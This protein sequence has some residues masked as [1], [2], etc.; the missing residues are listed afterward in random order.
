MIKVLKFNWLIMLLMQLNIHDIFEKREIRRLFR[1]LEQG[2][3][4]LWTI[5]NLQDA[6]FKQL[7]DLLQEIEQT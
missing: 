4:S 1:V 7:C 2:W 6:N 5:I 3:T